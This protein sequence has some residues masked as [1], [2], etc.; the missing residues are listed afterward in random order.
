MDDP[1]KRP[2]LFHPQLRDKPRSYT[3]PRMSWLTKW[4]FPESE[5]IGWFGNV[6]RDGGRGMYC[7]LEQYEALPKSALIDQGDIKIGPK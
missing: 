2:D 3:Y 6:K 5:R 7:T 1:Q 4:W